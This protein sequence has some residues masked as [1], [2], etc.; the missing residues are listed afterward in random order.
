MKANQHGFN[1]MELLT[2]FA[3][4]SIVSAL[5]IPLYTQYF[6]KTR[7]MEAASTL[8]R[9][10]LAMEQYHAEHQSYEGAT[11]T[12]LHFAE[13]TAKNSYRLAIQKADSNDYTLAAEPMGSQAEKDR[14]QLLS[15]NAAGEKRV[16]GQV[17]LEECW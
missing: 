5:T 1:L 16:S 12:A 17:P 14:C 4:V 9:L 8:S 15:L 10:A 2:T 13:Y 7:R 6:V 11:L 3:I